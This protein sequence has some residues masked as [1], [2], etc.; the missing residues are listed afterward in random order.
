MIAEYTRGERRRI[1]PEYNR[2][3]A[4][5][6]YARTT[7]NRARAG[8]LGKQQRSLP[9]RD[10]VDPGY[11]RLKYS[12][13]ADDQILGFIGPS[14]E[15]EDIKAKLAKHLR[16]SLGVQVNAEMILST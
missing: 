16:D 12:R 4:R 15:A 3:S 14:P 2:V 10:P 7:G 5:L 11:R 8:D 1:N 6:N 9:S 13:Y